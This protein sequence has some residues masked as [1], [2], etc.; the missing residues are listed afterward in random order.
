MCYAGAEGFAAG[1]LPFVATGL[2]AGEP[3]LVAVPEQNIALLRDALGADATRVRF[4]DMS[5]AGRNPG[6]IIP[7]VLRAFVDEHAGQPVRVLSESTWTGRSAIEYPACVQHEALVNLALVG[8]PLTIMCA[9]DAAGL[10]LHVLADAERT[11]PVLLD[12]G[13]RRRSAGY[14]S[15]EAVAAEFN[16]P[17]EEP[18]GTVAWF[19][20]DVGD[21]GAVRDFVANHGRRAGLRAERVA[22]LQLAANELA[23]NSVKHASGTG[24]VRLWYDRDQVVCEISDSGTINDPLAGRLPPSADSDRG[25]GLLLVNFLCDLV[26]IRTGTQGTA[27]RLYLER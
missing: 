4:R 5:R 25:R 13:R 11:H 20:F 22:D 1:A 16:R 12:G 23:T 24:L 3:V 19:S 10:E 26:R 9:Y 27:V 15:P 7:W 6:R 21:L 2:A 17:L 8:A 18:T 14:A